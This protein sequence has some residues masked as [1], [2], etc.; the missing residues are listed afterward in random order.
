M[1]VA[2]IYMGLQDPLRVAVFEG[3]LAQGKTKFGAY[4]FDAKGSVYFRRGFKGTL[5]Y[6][7][8]RWAYRRTSP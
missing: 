7:R 5:V 4:L 1:K 8:S 2:S 3:R 6:Y